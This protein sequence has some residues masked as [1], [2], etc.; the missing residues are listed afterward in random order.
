VVRVFGSLARASRCC[1]GIALLRALAACSAP[2]S[3]SAQTVLTRDVPPSTRN[4]ALAFDGVD[5]YATTGTAQFPS[6]RSAQTIS[7]WFR[8]ESASGRRA[9]ITL[10]KDR[11][12]GVELALVNGVLGAY[13]VFSNRVL[14]TA[15]K[16][17]S[18]G[19]WHHAAYTTDGV[20]NQI[21]IDGA[22]AASSVSLPDERTPTTC[23]LGT[24][25][26]TLDLFKGSIDDFRVFNLVRT[27]AQIAAEAAGSFSGEDPGSVLDLPCNEEAGNIVFDHSPLGNDGDLGDGFEPRIPARVPSGAPADL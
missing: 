1:I 14:V 18:A 21:Y 4:L 11:D 23:W 17:V 10:R 2:V 16:P 27:P 5:D 3:D 9:L 24:L 25:D 26:G 19:T 6:G 22:L 12:S 13:R 7:A 20:T 8:L 15:T